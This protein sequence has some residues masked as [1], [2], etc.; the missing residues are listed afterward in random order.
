MRKWGVAVVL[1]ALAIPSRA[2]AQDVAAAGALFDRGL[3]DMEAKRFTT[4]CPALD[5]SFRLDPRAGT[6]FTL[7]ECEAKWGHVASAVTHYADYLAR[8]E[9]M[10]VEQ[11]AR[12]REREHI[13]R[14]Q[15]ADLKPKIPLLTIRVAGAMPPGMTI[16]RDGHEL[17]H[18]SLGSALPVDPGEHVVTCTL[19]SGD[20]REVKVTIA[21]GDNKTIDIEPPGATEN[22]PPADARTSAP[23]VSPVMPPEPRSHLAWTLAVGG[24]ALLAIGTGAVTGGMA[25]GEKSIVDANCIG[26]MCNAT[27]LSAVDSGRTLG[28]V[29]TIGFITGAVALA[30]VII[31]AATE[32]KKHPSTISLRGWGLAW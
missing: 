27:G 28:L 1:V 10:P 24:V 16:S 32:P 7:A 8:Y 2:R 30:G 9:Q 12:Q 5:E 29:S 4:A 21:L 3:A 31:L 20:K 15:L 11:R 23:A 6:L 25:L 17:G 26:T 22:A 13:A 19:A 14:A 18:A